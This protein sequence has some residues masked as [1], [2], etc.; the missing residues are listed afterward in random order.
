M[1]WLCVS[2][3]GLHGHYLVSRLVVVYVLFH[4]STWRAMKRIGSGR[5]LN[6]ILGKTSRNMLIFTML[7]VLSLMF[8]TLHT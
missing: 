3:L 1:A 2:M 4:C 8:E 5:E 7:T 6:L